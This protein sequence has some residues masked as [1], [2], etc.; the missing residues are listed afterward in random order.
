MLLETSPAKCRANVTNLLMLQN[1]CVK[2]DQE[3][4]G[5]RPSPHFLLAGSSRGRRVDKGFCLLQE[6]VAVFI[7]CDSDSKYPQQ[8]FQRVWI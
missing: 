4:R 8:K 2:L 6:N 3:K 1:Q 7:A 5:A